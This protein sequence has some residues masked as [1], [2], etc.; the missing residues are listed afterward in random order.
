MPKILL[1]A[2]VLALFVVPASAAVSLSIAVNDKPYDATP[3]VISTEK[4]S[5]IAI[6]IGGAV[7]T[8][9]V[10]LPSVPGLVQHGASGT[11]GKISTYAFFVTPAKAGDIT[12]PAFNIDASGQVIHIRPIRLIARD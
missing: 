11:P 12:I 5:T 9:Q 6:S 8:G 10:F 2:L 7:V 4:P 1:A 3:I